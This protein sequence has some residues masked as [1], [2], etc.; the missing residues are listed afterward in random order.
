MCS[1]DLP[2]TI[3]EKG[4]GARLKEARLRRGLTQVQPAALELMRSYASTP[5]QVLHKVRIPNM[6]PFFFTALKV[7]TTLAFIG[8]IVALAVQSKYGAEVLTYSETVQAVST[9]SSAAEVVRG[10]GYSVDVAASGAEALEFLD[11]ETSYA[12][13]IISAY[14]WLVNERGAAETGGI[15]SEGYRYPGASHGP[16]RKSV[17]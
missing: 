17:V 13:L 14:D 1:S 6:L 2:T 5:T 8:A 12:L 16:D 4:I 3:D 7:S 9:T 15:A 11:S 10:L